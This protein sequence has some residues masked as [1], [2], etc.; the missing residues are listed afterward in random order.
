M[1]ASYLHAIIS[2]S[3]H[4]CPMYV[5][6]HVPGRS[7]DEIWE[8]F[9]ESFFDFCEESGYDKILRVLGRTLFDFLQVSKAP[10]HWLSDIC[11]ESEPTS[12]SSI[13]DTSLRCGYNSQHVKLVYLTKI[14]RFSALLMPRVRPDMH[15]S[16]PL[17]PCVTAVNG[18]AAYLDANRVALRTSKVR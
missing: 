6:M 15:Q 11:I 18:V 13:C 1:V 16:V 17:R 10:V 12:I 7:T 4:T 14:L 9:G 5:I 3:R 8:M 2:F